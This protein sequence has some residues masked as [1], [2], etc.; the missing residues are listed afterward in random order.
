M[1]D[2]DCSNSPENIKSESVL[3]LTQQKS[4]SRNPSYRFH[5]PVFNN[6]RFFFNWLWRFL[7]LR[8]FS[9]NALKLIF[10][11][12]LR[13]PRNLKTIL[14]KPG[15]HIND[16]M[17]NLL[18]SRNTILDKNIS[19]LRTNALKSNHKEVDKFFTL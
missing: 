11:R 9:F 12:L 19:P 13:L 14:L 3:Y 18:P 15:N 2:I 10:L 17:T 6:R 1:H 4:F 7:F 8:Q 5:S 16:S